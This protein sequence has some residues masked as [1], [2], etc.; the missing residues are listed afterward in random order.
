MLTRRSLMRGALAAAPF[1]LLFKRRLAHAA[2]GYGPLVRDPAGILDLPAGFRYQIVDQVGQDM[3]DGYRV[4]GRPD[5]M[6]CF[7]LADGRL[8]L[9]RNHELVW[10]DSRLGPYKTSARPAQAYSRNQFGCVTRVVLDPE[11]YLRES[12]NLVLV[13]TARNC[14]GGPGPGN[15]WLSAEEPTAL[16]IGGD[17]G[18]VFE[19]SVEAST[20]QPPARI[21]GYGKMNHEAAWVDPETS[22]CYLTEDEGDACFYRF[23]PA[24][25]AQPYQGTLQ[26]MKVV[27]RDR[28]DLRGVSRVGESWAIEWVTVP[29]GSGSVRSRA[30]RVGAAILRKGEGLWVSGGEVLFNSSTGGPGNNGQIYQLVPAGSGSTLTLIAVGRGDATLQN[31]DCMALTPW[32]ELFLCE[33]GSGSQYVRILHED[34]TLSTFAKNARDNVEVAGVCFSPDGMAMFLNLFGAGMTLAITGP[35]SVPFAVAADEDELAP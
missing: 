25:P 11:T 23:V 31:P 26:A 19:C 32:G 21:T 17:H 33:D 34:G 30:Q 14:Q 3:S 22:I 4:P 9:M 1:A 16:T 13:G 7:T 27:G 8:A 18:Y 28:V 10:T 5:G 6:G 20:L 15:T 2:A 12:S 29:S 24:N 35:F